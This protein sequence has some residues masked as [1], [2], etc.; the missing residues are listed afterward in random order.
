[1]FIKKRAY[2]AVLIVVLC[3]VGGYIS[4]FMFTLA[5]LLLLL[6]LVLCIYEIFLLYFVKKN[7]V[8]C[9]RECA[10][11]FSNG[12]ENEIKLH[13]SNTYPFP[14]TLEII[15]EI[16]PQFQMRD[17]LYLLQKK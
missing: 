16:P 4:V 1:M 8:S 7:A 9:W 15:D 17:L 14:V 12:D 3:F 2:M 10:E 13:L 6:L 11:R 5:Q